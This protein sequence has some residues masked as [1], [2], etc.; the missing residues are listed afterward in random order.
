MGL[1]YENKDEE[2]IVAYYDTPSD[3]CSSLFIKKYNN[4]FEEIESN[5]YYSDDDA[6]DRLDCE[7]ELKESKLNKEILEIFTEI[8]S[9]INYKDK[10]VI[11]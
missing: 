1:I 11:N 4:K 2:Y 10:T 7:S 9:F 6:C 5:E 3:A 8:V